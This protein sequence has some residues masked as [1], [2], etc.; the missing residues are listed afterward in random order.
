[1][2]VKELMKLLEKFEGDSQVIIETLDKDG[3]TV[4]K[5]EICIFEDENN[6]TIIR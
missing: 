2:T 6:N 3:Y 4:D 1:M 5:N